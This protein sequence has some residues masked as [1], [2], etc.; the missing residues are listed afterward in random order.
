M[1]TRLPS[2]IRATEV[3]VNSRALARVRHGVELSRGGLA[4]PAI[5]TRMN[6]VT[7]APRP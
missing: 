6:R 4:R 3:K 7:I 2:I 1:P 5:V